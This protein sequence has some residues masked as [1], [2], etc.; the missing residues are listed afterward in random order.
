M[1]VT[2]SRQHADSPSAFGHVRTRAVRH[3]T[4]AEV[5]ELDSAING[6]AGQAD[7]LLRRG[8]PAVLGLVLDAHGIIVD[9]HP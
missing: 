1:K 9:D 5:H 2:V 7:E 3:G 4:E 8:H 6:L